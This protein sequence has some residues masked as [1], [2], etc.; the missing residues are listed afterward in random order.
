MKA[1]DNLRGEEG[2]E[3]QPAWCGDFRDSFDLKRP[4]AYVFSIVNDG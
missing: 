1:Y 4:M 2:I 3:Q